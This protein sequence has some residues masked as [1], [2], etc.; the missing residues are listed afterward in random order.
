MVQKMYS[1]FPKVRVEELRLNESDLNTKRM[2]DLMAVSSGPMPLYLHVVN[3]ILRDLRIIQQRTGA[4]FNY[5]EFKRL[6]TA[7]PLTDAQ[8][9][10]LKQRLDTL[11]SFMVKA[12]T[13]DAGRFRH[14]SKAAPMPAGRGN[15]WTPAVG[16]QLSTYQIP[17]HSYEC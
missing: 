13:A 12:H 2:L 17:Q 15:D 7:E 9:A 8:L 14:H 16:S 11:E 1:R 10:P 5:G 3:R 6:I 4:T